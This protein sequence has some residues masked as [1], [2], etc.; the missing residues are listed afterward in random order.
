V[1]RLKPNTIRRMG[2]L[3]AWLWRLSGGL[4]GDGFGR[5]PFL[6]LTTIGRKTL[7]PR[8]TPVLYFQD[9]KDLIVI[10][11]FG[12]NDQ[13][14]A[15]LLNLESCPEAEVLIKDKRSRRAAHSV[16]P[17]DKQRLWPQIV[18]LYPNFAVYQQRTKREIPLVRLTE[19]R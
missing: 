6:L 18:K 14:P 3:H 12:G 4:L 19:K 15:W 17:E 1:E 11:S 16:S 13:P 8:T 2:G 5:A 10:G 9:G 7:K